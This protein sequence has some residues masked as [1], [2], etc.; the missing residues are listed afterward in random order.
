MSIAP[1]LINPFGILI[2]PEPIAATSDSVTPTSFSK[3]TPVDSVYIKPPDPGCCV[4]NLGFSSV[5]VSPASVAS[6]LY[7]PCL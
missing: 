7:L 3:G 1:R 4:L 2:P 5:S 6:V